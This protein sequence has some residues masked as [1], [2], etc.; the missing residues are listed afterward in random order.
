[1]GKKD[2]TEPKSFDIG[3]VPLCSSRFGERNRITLPLGTDSSPR[4]LGAAT[5]K[6]GGTEP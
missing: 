6:K 3:P 5:G 1:M 4:L 2:G